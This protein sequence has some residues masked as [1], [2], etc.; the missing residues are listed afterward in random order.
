MNLIFNEP[1]QIILGCFQLFQ[2]GVKDLGQ[3]QYSRS[4]KG[5]L[6]NV[7]CNCAFCILYFFSNAFRPLGDDVLGGTG[8]EFS[9]SN[10]RNPEAVIRHN[11]HNA[12]RPPLS[13][14]PAFPTYP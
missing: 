6:Y 7:S 10:K 12:S 14:S 3:V 13:S 8:V 11:H 1:L 4:C 2:G 5:P 9:G